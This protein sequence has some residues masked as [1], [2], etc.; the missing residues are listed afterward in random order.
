MHS[1]FPKLLPEFKKI[2]FPI[3]IVGGGRWAKIIINEIFF[4][5]TNIKKVILVTKNKKILSEF[6]ENQKNKIEQQVNFKFLKK[7]KYKYA[8]VANKNKDHFKVSKTL[9]KNKINLLIEKPIVEN[10]NQYKILKRISAF[11]RCKVF[12]SSPFFFSYYFYFFNKKYLKNKKYDVVLEWND[13]INEIR[14]GQTKKHDFTLNYVEDTVY[15]FYG[16]LSA[17]YGKKQITYKD[18][19]SKKNYGFLKV[20]YG[21]NI[22]L[23]SCSRKKNNSR[24]RKIIF[25]SKLKKY[26][27]DFSNDNNL[28]FFQNGSKKKLKFN[29]CQ[30]TLKYQI[31]CFLNYKNFQNKLLLNDIN[32]I[33]SLMELI[34]KIKSK[35]VLLS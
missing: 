14:D 30:R 2:N 22:C 12:M 4:N 23:L 6:S 34:N 26:I 7:K 15:H 27:I 28:K 3:I 13:Q 35:K 20:K 33:N 18:S 32:K 9:L 5:F 31:F 21:K 10:F 29:F 24:V 25:S 11:N 8:I 16:I 17:I 1:C 19:L